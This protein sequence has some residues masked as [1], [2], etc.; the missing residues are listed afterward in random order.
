MVQ[1][2]EVRASISF[3]SWTEAV[4][5][6]EISDFSLGKYVSG[7]GQVVHSEFGFMIHGS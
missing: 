5:Q 4:S 2:G 1:S 7:I 3:L 6:I